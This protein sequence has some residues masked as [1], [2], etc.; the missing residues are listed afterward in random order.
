MQTGYHESGADAHILLTS[1]M[2]YDI[3]LYAY[4]CKC[5]CF[6]NLKL[7][8]SLGIIMLQLLD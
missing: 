4:Q 3:Y 6:L 2:L 5:L 1:L 8:Y 7:A